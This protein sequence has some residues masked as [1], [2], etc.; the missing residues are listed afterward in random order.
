MSLSKVLK[1]IESSVQDIVKKLGFDSAP[2]SVDLA[3]PGFGDFTCNV[4]FL[5]AKQAKKKPHQ[6]AQDIASE[7]SKNL[8]PNL[9]KVDAHQSGYLNFFANQ[10]KINSIVINAALDE[11]Y[12]T[13]DLGGYMSVVV[14]HTSVNPNKALHIGHIR[15]IVIGDTI[16]RILQKTNYNVKVLNYIDDSG[17]QVADVIV[18]FK[19]LGFSE[20]P[21]KGQKFDH[22]CG[23]TVYVQTTEKY[24]T[25]KELEEKRR[26]ILQE[27]EDESSDTA[28]FGKKITRM[29]LA[30]QLK[31]CWEMGVTYDCL[32]FESQIIHSKLWSEIFEKMKSM[33]LIKY[34]TEGKNANCWV[35]EAPGEE[36]KVL[37]RSNGVATYVAKDMPY[38]AWKLGI[39]ADPF[40][41]KEYAKQS[42][43][44]ILWETTLE[45][46]SHQK[47]S[48]SGE[49]VITVID[50][51]QA[52]LQKIIT[53]LME[54]F[55]HKK[56]AYLHLSYES[57]TLSGDTV[58]SLGLEAEGKQAQMS[59]R[60]GLYINADSVLDSLKQRVLVE[61][62]KRNEDLDESSLNK[63]AKD[64]AVGT[65]RYE[66][67]KQDLDKI[68]TFDAKKSLSL[69]GDTCSYIQY[70]YA[71]AKRI[72]EKANSSPDFEVS[73]DALCTEHEINLIKDIGRLDICIKDAAQNLSP[74]VIARYCYELA[75]SFNGFYEHVPVLNIDD[76]KLV[77]ARLCL[78]FCFKSTLE[79]A[80]NCL[81]ISA[82][83]RM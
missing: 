45:K 28:K 65:L 13:V 68:I 16:S 17:L 15:N 54:K 21:P 63:I 1:E 31:T 53:N 7:Y 74:K 48:F 19:H 50:S 52:R 82:P 42:D 60:K 71:R 2:F 25:D 79:K 41:Y 62:K 75:V 6:I 83:N 67:I 73:F 12:G 36:D 20:N 24:E 81:G 58:Q 46:N 76:E 30:E 57:V 3:K 55:K 51:R 43:G 77:N 59:G 35:I 27:L 22:Y 8:G 78:V 32:N 26:K 72:L 33:N 14:E 37:V 38:A 64:V 4:A 9:K 56:D 10:G 61:S 49:K 11:N 70:S 47:M 18:G 66:M 40:Y 5:L 29:V 80:L 44:K 39:V 69:E 23:D 34:E